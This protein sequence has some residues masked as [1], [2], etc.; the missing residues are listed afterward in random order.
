MWGPER[1]IFIAKSKRQ[2]LKKLSKSI[3]AFENLPFAAHFM[4]SSSFLQLFLTV[5]VRRIYLFGQTSPNICLLNTTIQWKLL[6]PEQPLLVGFQKYTIFTAKNREKTRKSQ[7]IFF[8]TGRKPFRFFQ[9]INHQRNPEKQKKA[10]QKFEKH[11]EKK[12]NHLKTLQQLSKNAGK[13]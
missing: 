1:K 7:A 6:S 3:R 13:T 4:K 9:R 10:I 11:L 8:R 2:I 5:F 12:K